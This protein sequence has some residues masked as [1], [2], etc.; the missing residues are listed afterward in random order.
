MSKNRDKPVTIKS[1]REI[2]LMRTANRMVAET[3]RKVTPMVKEGATTQEINDAV[4]TC[5]RE[6]GG[7]PSFLGLYGF[8]ASACFAT[9]EEIVHAP[10]SKKK[11]KSGD[12]VT[13]DIGVEY[14]G[15]YGDSARTYGIGKISPLAQ[16]LIDNCKDVL[17]IAEET[18]RPGTRLLDL[19]LAMEKCISDAGFGIVRDYGGHGIGRYPHEDPFIPNYVAGY[20]GDLSLVLRKGHVICIEPMVTAGTYKTKIIDDWNLGTVITKDRK[21]SAHWEDC[22]AVT[23]EGCEVLDRTEDGKDGTELN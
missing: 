7:R 13:V 6:Q 5:I 21:L 11:L 20:N 18:I 15:Y 2:D 1:D 4:D 19:C 23:D 9:N 3:F 12:I 17:K 16:A 14:K 8:P 10:P 22:F